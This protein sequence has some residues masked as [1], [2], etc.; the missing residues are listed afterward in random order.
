ML[1]KDLTFKKLFIFTA[2]GVKCRVVAVKYLTILYYSA[3]FSGWSFVFT[4]VLFI[5][6]TEFGLSGCKK[7]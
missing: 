2:T 3:L 7:A 4:E 1:P 5:L 6:E